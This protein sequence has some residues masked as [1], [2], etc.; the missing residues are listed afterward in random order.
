M[1]KVDDIE[2]ITRAIDGIGGGLSSSKC[3]RLIEYAYL[4]MFVGLVIIGICS[5]V[6]IRGFSFMLCVAFP[7]S[8]LSL[9]LMT[10]IVADFLKTEIGKKCDAF[11]KAVEKCVAEEEKGAENKANKEA[12][13]ERR[14][15]ELL[16]KFMESK[17]QK[18][19]LH[20]H[21]PE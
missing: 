4:S 2:R 17:L 6:N 20:V 5:F 16:L 10:A 11:V 8:L 12:S 18:G 1:M 15:H 9:T 13:E 14:I 3:K 19:D 21:L 7:L